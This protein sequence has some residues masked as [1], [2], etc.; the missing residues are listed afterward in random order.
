MPMNKSIDMIKVEET[1]LLDFQF[2]IIDAMNELGLNKADLAR[3]LGVSR[4]RVSQML[5]SE[6]N[7]TLQVIARAMASLGRTIQYLP[8]EVASRHAVASDRTNRHNWS[9]VASATRGIGD[10]WAVVRLKGKTASTNAS[11]A[12]LRFVAQAA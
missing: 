2:S 11:N 3:A 8:F 6:A 1:A 12:N 10:D 4:A 9:G 5:M 7:P